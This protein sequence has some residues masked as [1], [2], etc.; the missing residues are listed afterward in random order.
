MQ[1]DT[2]S[3]VP[4][5]RDDIAHDSPRPH[6]VMV[7]GN[8]V[9]GDSRVEKAAMAAHRAGYDVTVLGLI[10][11]TV[12]ALGVIDEIPV[13]RVSPPYAMHQHWS[14]ERDGTRLEVY[15]DAIAARRR[16]RR[17]HARTRISQRSNLI[18]RILGTTRRRVED[19]MLAVKR[20]QPNLRLF[21]S[22]LLTKLPIS[23]IWRRAWPYIADLELAF[24]DAIVDL[25]PDIV[26]A[27]DRHIL[28]GTRTAAGILKASGTATK[29][30]YDAHEWLPGVEFQGPEAHAA[31]WLAAESELIGSAD[32][33]ITVSDELAHMLKR[34]HALNVTPWVVT[35]SPPAAGPQVPDVSR[36]SVRDDCGLDRD[37]ELLVYV[38]GIAKVRGLETVVTALP[39]LPEVHLALV[40]PPDRKRRLEI[41]LLAK[42]LGVQE[43]VHILDYVPARSVASYISSASV[44]ISPVEPIAN[45]QH[46][47][48]TKIREYLHA[49]LPIVASDLQTLTPFLEESGAGAVHRGGDHEDFARVVKEVLANRESYV[50]SITEELLTQHSWERQEATLIEAWG[51]LVGEKEPR[52]RLPRRRPRLVVG[53]AV[54]FTRSQNLLSAVCD[55]YEGNGEVIVR[56]SIVKRSDRLAMKL[57]EYRRLVAESD[58]LVLESL[59]PLF[60]SLVESPEAHLIHLASVRPVAFMLDL[61]AGV[62]LDELAHRVPDYWAMALDASARERISLQGHRTRRLLNDANVPVLATSPYPMAELMNVTWVPTVV[63]IEPHE[64]MHDGPLHVLIAPGP[65]AG[66]DA[67]VAETVKKLASRRVVVQVPSSNE[68]ARSLLRKV[69]VLVDSLGHG[70]YTDLAVQ[71]MG[72]GCVAISRLD[73]EVR[74][75][76]P[77]SCPVVD[78]TPGVVP[79]L[80][81]DL[82]ADR[83]R[84]SEIGKRSLS[85]AEE[86]HGGRHSAQ[87]VSRTMGWS[88]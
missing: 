26:H 56:R 6:M 53:P 28:P 80:I 72:Y 55:Q 17:L 44:G 50:G 78:A 35:N 24:A 59:Q 9:V 64:A 68:E 47:L 37:T 48:A 71:A 51:G 66:P 79:D 76:L 14:H 38:G 86:I 62:D 13:F 87:I 29:W 5:S 21:F 73:P 43:R 74:S 19:A 20:A 15:A 12:P 31:A 57:G 70:S 46:S 84:Q 32:A 8:R 27:H 69:D 85:Y 39:S 23:G 61:L 18:R 83:D 40:A 58:G 88:S 36:I 49:R 2:V 7:V 63:E 65:R 4:A 52:P 10:H 41:V 30:V 11:R 34:R 33:V 77:S 81:S 60:G 45:Y 54:D 22:Y 1:S 16:L 82:A 75:V 67:L 25:Q 42:E 3:D